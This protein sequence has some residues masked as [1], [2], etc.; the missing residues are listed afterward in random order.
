MICWNIQESYENL[1]CPEDK[2]QVLMVQ[3]T[4]KLGGSILS[5]IPDML[6]GQLVGRLLPEI[7]RSPHLEKLIRE[8]DQLS[9][10]HNSLIPV[11]HCL[12]SPGGPMKFSLE[13]RHRLNNVLIP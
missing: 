3:D 8:C 2:R 1:S 10:G 4:L 9:P 5:K 7:W 12:L 6:A 11:C 13:V